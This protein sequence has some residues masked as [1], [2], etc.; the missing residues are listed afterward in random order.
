MSKKLNLQGSFLRPYSAVTFARPLAMTEPASLR[1]GHHESAQVGAS[2]L[3]RFPVQ[4]F[5][6]PEFML[7]LLASL[8]LGL[9][10]DRGVDG[11]S[12]SM[13]TVSAWLPI[14]IEVKDYARTPVSILPI[15]AFVKPVQPHPVSDFHFFFLLR[16]ADWPTMNR[17]HATR[18]RNVK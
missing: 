12:W 2:A 15:N 17:V 5:A 7:H 10:A 13:T 8:P 1:V 16:L 3:P 9:G 14:L 6:V 4:P 18:P 11:L